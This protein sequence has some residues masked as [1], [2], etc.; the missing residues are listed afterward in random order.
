MRSSRP[1][2]IAASR[3]ASSCRRWPTPRWRRLLTARGYRVTGFENVLGRAVTDDD[4]APDL[5]GMSIAALPPRRVA[6]V[7]G[8]GA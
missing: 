3:C 8:R 2:P 5:N 1:G 7:D 6:Y 4:R